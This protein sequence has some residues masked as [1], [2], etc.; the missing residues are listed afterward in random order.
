MGVFDSV[1]LIAL[2]AWVG[3]ILFF[4]FGV[5]PLIFRVLSAEDAGR[6]VRALFPRYYMW[7]AI[8]GAIAL[9]AFVAVPLCYPEYR[10]PAI[11]VQSLVILACILIML[12]SANSLTPSINAAR[13]AGL[14]G[15]ERFQRLHRRSVVLNALVLV[16]GLGLLIAHANR[17]SARTSGLRQLTPAELAR[18][19][20]ELEPVIKQIETKYGFRPV[21]AGQGD[22]PVTPGASVDPE[23][24]KEIESYYQQKRERELARRGKTSP[25]ARSQDRP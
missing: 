22:S 15:S 23:M 2:T 17:P 13:D 10:G 20:A 8:A 9:P 21:P 16:A 24:I 1:Y 3:G 7:G 6:F 11:A 25:D 4:S 18:V 12:Y 5:A 14:E 19:D